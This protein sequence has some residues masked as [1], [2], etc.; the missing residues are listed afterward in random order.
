MIFQQKERKSS[1]IYVEQSIGDSSTMC[2]IIITVVT[3]AKYVK[4]LSLQNTN[5]PQTISTKCSSNRS[6]IDLF[7]TILLDQ[8]AFMSNFTDNNATYQHL[9]SSFGMSCYNSGYHFLGF[10]FSMFQ[11]YCFTKLHH[12]TSS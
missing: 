12:H 6:A 8:L 7:L 1:A 3:T 4:Q 5:T 10:W 9:T 2:I 11:N